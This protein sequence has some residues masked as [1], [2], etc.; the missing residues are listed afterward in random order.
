MALTDDQIQ[1]AISV[2]FYPA[3]PGLDVTQALNDGNKQAIGYGIYS[4]LSSAAVTVDIVPRFSRID[5]VIRNHGK[6]YTLTLQTMKPDR[7]TGLYTA[8]STDVIYMRRVKG[9]GNNIGKTRTFL[10]TFQMFGQRKPI[11]NMRL[12]RNGLTHMIVEIIICGD[13]EYLIETETV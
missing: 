1:S 8:D 12:Q 2:S 6:R 7:S 9:K 10:T 11:R 5:S 13:N 4:L 3:A